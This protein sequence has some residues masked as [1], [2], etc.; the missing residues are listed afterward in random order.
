M[1]GNQLAL[2][3]DFVDPILI[4]RANY[5]NPSLAIKS[6][7]RPKISVLYTAVMEMGLECIC[8]KGFNRFRADAKI[9]SCRQSENM[10]TPPVRRSHKRE[11]GA[12]TN[13][14]GN[15]LKLS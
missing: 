6:W 13:K 12:G 7:A 9:A 15:C 3:F 14:K 11:K 8:W 10:D 4:E 2:L 5:S 1:R